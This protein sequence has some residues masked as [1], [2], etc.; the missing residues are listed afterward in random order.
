MFGF[1]K[2]LKEY[3]LSQEELNKLQYA[4][5]TTEKGTIWIKLFPESTPIAVSNFATLANEG[6]YNNLNFHRVIPYFMAQGV[7]QMVRV[8]EDLI[9]QL[10][11]KRLHL[12]N[13]IKKEVFQWLMQ[14]KIQGKPIFYLF[15]TLSSFRWWSH[16]FW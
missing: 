12:N 1:G 5:F 10:N 2:E 16:R 6:F 9:G 11:V 3:N 15:C 8:R 4:K 7:V 14:V 13:C